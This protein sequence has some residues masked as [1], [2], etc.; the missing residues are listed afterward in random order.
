[1]KQNPDY[2]RDRPAYLDEVTFMIV[3]DA[4]AAIMDLQEGNFDIFPY[5]TMDKA[6]LLKRQI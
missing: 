4:D 3:S 2:W 5:L 1:M 6:E